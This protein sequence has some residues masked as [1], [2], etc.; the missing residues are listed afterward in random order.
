MPGTKR[1]ILGYAS[2]TLAATL[3][4]LFLIA[5]FS[6]TIWST[7]NGRDATRIYLGEAR[8]S[9]DLEFRPNLDPFHHAHRSRETTWSNTFRFAR[10]TAHTANPGHGLRDTWTLDTPLI[11]LETYTNDLHM[12]FPTY[13]SDATID[14]SARMFYIRVRRLDAALWP[15]PL[16]PLLLGTFLLLS[17][18]R[19][20]LRASLGLCPRCAYDLRATP[21]T[22]PCPECGTP[23]LSSP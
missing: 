4:A 15:L 12:S 16:P 18:Y 11:V 14:P 2:L 8:F 22:S 21:P 9:L 5:G 1:R 20:R 19:L 23:R 6:T 7:S 3:T 17:A 10:P 13:V